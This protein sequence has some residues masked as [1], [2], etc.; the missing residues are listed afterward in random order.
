MIVLR[1]PHR[2]WSVG[3]PGS[4]VTIG[5][6]DGIHRGHQA[7][8]ADLR[9]RSA[10]LPLAVITFD[11]HP[12]T[13]LA[14]ERAPLLLTTQE[15]K[16]ELLERVGVDIVAVLEFD[17]ETAAMSPEAFVEEVLVKRLRARLV[18]VGVDFR[19]G[20]HRAGDLEL[21]Q[22]LGAVHGFEVDGIELIGHEMPYSSTGIRRLIAAGDVVS[23]AE[24]LGRPYE[25][26]GAVVAGDGRGRQ[27]GFPTA[28]LDIPKGIAIP[29]RGVYAVTAVIDGGAHRGVV[30]V[31]V[32]PTF[33][34]D[35][36]VVE[37]HLIDHDRDLYGMDVGIEFVARLRDERRFDGVDS[38]VAQIRADVAEANARLA[39]AGR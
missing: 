1:G 13:V 15:H 22:R 31:G 37:V 11:P 38:L 34:G 10:D 17:L 29:R 33:G 25:L 20:R 32:R 2:D 14:P 26:R 28:N 7:V 5:V 36:E 4:A 27:I 35:R 19:F 12:M 18:A 24:C 8:L 6:Y 30:N 23:A 3:T 16:L 39:A 9:A 21:L